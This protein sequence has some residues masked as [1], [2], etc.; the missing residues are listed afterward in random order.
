MKIALGTVQFGIPYGINNIKGIPDRNEIKNIFRLAHDSGISILDTAPAYGDAEVKIGELSNSK[1][2]V[3]TKFSYANNEIEL[4]SQLSKSLQDLGTSNVY[5]YLAHNA[6]NL[7]KVP[8]L[9]RVLCEARDERLIKKIGY[10]LYNPDQLDM[11]LSNGHIPDLVQIPYS[12]LDRKF[13]TALSILKNLGAEIHVRSV[14]LQG[15]YFKNP[16][17]LTVKLAPL[18]SQLVDLHKLCKMHSLSIGALALNFVVQ[19][20]NVD[21]VVIGVEKESQLKQNLEMIQTLENQKGLMEE[22]G[23]LVV[24]NKNL[25]N[26]ANW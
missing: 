8:E 26:P 22:V 19:N 11:L 5:G 10:S 14:F 15:L 7:L 25:L 20:L 1:F 16:N 13:E 24:S 3:V 4:R 12:L 21:Q 2:K 23:K 18:K 6:D 9:W 17:E